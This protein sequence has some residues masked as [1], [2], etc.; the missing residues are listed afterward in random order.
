MPV[1]LQPEDEEQSLDASGT[2][3]V[4]SIA[5]ES[6][7]GG[8][9][10]RSRRLANRQLDEIR[11]LACNKPVSGDEIPRGAVITVLSNLRIF[12]TMA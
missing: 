11:W 6:V 12:G 5:V 4:K 8:A 9:D 10:G 3:F 2:S 7:S 1:I